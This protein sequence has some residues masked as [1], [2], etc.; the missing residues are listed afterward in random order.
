MGNKKIVIIV[1]ALIL[2]AG[3]GSF[4]FAGL[5]GNFDEDSI[6]YRNNDTTYNKVDNPIK[7]QDVPVIDNNVGNV[8]DGNNETE[9]PDVEINN[10]G[11]NTT[12]TPSQTNPTGS[13]SSGSGNKKPGTSG[14]NG[15]SGTQT[16]GSQNGGNSSNVGGNTG[17]SGSNSGNQEPAPSNPGG[18]TGSESETF[19]A[20]LVYSYTG[21]LLTKEDITLTVKTNKEIDSISSGW[22]KVSS[23]EYKRAFSSNTAGELVVTSGSDSITLPYNIDKIDKVP[24]VANVSYSET[25]K[26]YHSIEVV[27]TSDKP[28]EAVSEKDWI[29]GD[30]KHTITR[31][32]ENNVD[33]TTI[34][35][36]DEA[37]NQTKVSYVIA[38]YDDSPITNTNKD[39]DV[40]SVVITYKKPIEGI[41]NWEK[42][43]NEDYQAVV[44]VDS[45][46]GGEIILP[47][48]NKI[49]YDAV[50]VVTVDVKRY[51]VNGNLVTSKRKSA[52]YAIV[53][54]ES[55]KKLA[56]LEGWELKNEYTLTKKEI[57]MKTDEKVKISDSNGNS[58]TAKYTV[59]NVNGIAPDILSID[60]VVGE[61]TVELTLKTTKAASIEDWTSI[62][63]LI[64]K[65]N[66]QISE[67]KNGVTE[68]IKISDSYGNK[69]SKELKLYYNENNEIII[70]V[71]SK[72]IG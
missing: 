66:Y 49:K 48:G 23:N 41:D 15:G 6:D 42:L 69:A 58:T 4:V 50:P 24:L 36:E 10:N 26:T 52:N 9:N 39:E 32:F 45:A 59:S 28:I 11:S 29:Y 33:E 63:G 72:I 2:I 5:E 46:E 13:G 27:I 44:S 20:T 51:D 61:D 18:N 3:T 54:I 37:K 70:E 12:T 34:I 62:V 60:K 8:D 67:V 30:D 31:T 71:D 14:S 47:N 64:F 21:S 22:E 40:I 65:K 35:L 55:S 56:P 17:T 68:T 1:I 7:G 38:N 25:K 19:T 43:E 16:G 53:T 57:T